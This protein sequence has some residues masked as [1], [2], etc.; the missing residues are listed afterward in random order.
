MI[1]TNHGRAER[2]PHLAERRLLFPRA[3]EVLFVSFP[4]TY[5]PAKAGIGINNVHVVVMGGKSSGSAP[6]DIPPARLH[7]TLSCM[8]IFGCSWFKR[9]D[10]QCPFFLEDTF[11]WTITNSQIE[12]P[13]PSNESPR[14]ASV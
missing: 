14:H 10:S 6:H 3:I 4:S 11:H 7:V 5:Q 1:A 9:R 12:H 2:K 13:D 8:A